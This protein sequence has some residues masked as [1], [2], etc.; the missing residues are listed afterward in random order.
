M[1][2]LRFALAIISSAVGFVFPPLLMQFLSICLSML[3]L[4]QILA[5]AEQHCL[6]SLIYMQDSIT[7]LPTSWNNS[8]SSPLNSQAASKKTQHCLIISAFCLEIFFSLFP[9]VP[10]I[11]ACYLFLHFSIFIFSSFCFS[12]PW[13]FTHFQKALQH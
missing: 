6:A 13:I 8:N 11:E 5:C 9:S 3:P 1:L 2:V 7:I 4:F 12:G 10:L